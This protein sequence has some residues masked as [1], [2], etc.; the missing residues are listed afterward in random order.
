MRN[1]AVNFSHT[2]R[3]IRKS[4]TFKQSF[5]SLPSYKSWKNQILRFS[6]C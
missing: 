4:V 5:N 6:A 3:V 1:T 2:I